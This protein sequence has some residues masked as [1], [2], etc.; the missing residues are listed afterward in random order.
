MKQLIIEG[1]NSLNGEVAISGAKNVATKLMIASLLTEDS[2][3]LDNLPLIGDVDITRQ[4]CEAIGAE[5][6]INDHSLSI[7]TRT[8]KTSKVREQTSKNRLSVLAISPLLHR[9]G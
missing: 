3:K 9:T 7:Q 4:I 5:V 2:I 6:A 8:I 1:G